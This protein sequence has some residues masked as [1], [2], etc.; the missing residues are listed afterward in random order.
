[1]WVENPAHLLPSCHL[2]PSTSLCLCPYFRSHDANNACLEQPVL[3]PD[4][5]QCWE[6]ETP[7]PASGAGAFDLGGR[8]QQ[9]SYSWSLLMDA[10]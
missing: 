3:V 8:E 7:S 5:K 4:I 10:S 2:S 9:G 1:M 6:M